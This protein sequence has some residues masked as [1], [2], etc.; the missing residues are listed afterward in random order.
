M[1]MPS[2]NLALSVALRQAG[3]IPL[4]VNLDCR[5]GELLALIGPS[6]SG[7][8]TVLRAIAGLY[9]PQEGRVVAAGDTWL[10]TGAGI[11]LAPQARSVGLVF[12]DYALF[13]HL[14]ALDNVR[15]AMLRLPEPERSRRAAELLA[16][17]H[18]Q[19]LDT[20][21][22]DA[23][24]GGQRQRVAIA[25]ALA[26]DPKVLL[27]D[28]PFSAVDRITRDALKEE[29]AALHRSLDIPMVL[30]THDLDEA[31]ALADRICVLHGGT[32]LQIGTPDEVRL[33]PRNVRVARL[34]G[35]TN[36]IPTQVQDQGR[37]HFG[38]QTLAVASTNGAAIDERVTALIPP[39]A[40]SLGGGTANAANAID[41]KLTNVQS[42]GDLTAVT[43]AFDGGELRFRLPSR[44]AAARRLQGGAALS[45]EVDPALTHLLRDD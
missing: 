8:S 29:L 43:L 4:D 15:L 45:V 1:R 44:E 3:P 41:G 33:R 31:Q 25:R 40:I 26:R 7:K 5:R 27:L 14:S 38:A 18:L 6:G 11:D 34:M 32:T 19:G 35:H 17:V 2:D 21:R 28:E 16:R 23:L 12:Q 42:L 30:V 36:L 37:I 22:P 13:P 24:S 10:D 20:R 9:R 39:D